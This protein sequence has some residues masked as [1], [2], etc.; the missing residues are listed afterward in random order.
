MLV[1]RRSEGQW[2]DVRHRSG[3]LIRVRVCNIRAGRYPNGEVDLVF[4]DAAHNFEVQRP[5][6]VVKTP[7]TP[8]AAE[9]TDPAPVQG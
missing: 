9:N 7:P 8:T 4:D 6:R 3:D 5:E 2:T 1:L